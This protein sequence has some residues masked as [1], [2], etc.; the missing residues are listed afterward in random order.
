MNKLQNAYMQVITE[1]NQKRISQVAQHIAFDMQK[2]KQLFKGDGFYNTQTTAYGQDGWIQLSVQ[3]PNQ[4]RLSDGRYV[5]VV[6]TQQ[7]ISFHWDPGQNGGRWDP[8]WDPYLQSVGGIDHAFSNDINDVQNDQVIQ[9]QDQNK[10]Q[11]KFSQLSINDRYQIW[12][13]YDQYLK[14]NKF[15]QWLQREV[16]RQNEEAKAQAQMYRRGYY[17]DQY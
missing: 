4:I 6:F 9:I 17:D 2:V 14:S 3:L 15:R 11:I 7:S 10:K 1:M 12:K 5:N 8:S 13:A 16:I